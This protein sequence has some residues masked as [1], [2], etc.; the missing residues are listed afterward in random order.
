MIAAGQLLDEI[1][2][3]CVDIPQ[4]WL[5]DRGDSEDDSQDDDEQKITRVRRSQR[6]GRR[7]FSIIK[8][9]R[10]KKQQLFLG[11]ARFIN[12]C[13]FAALPQ[14]RTDI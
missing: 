7:D 8:S 13:T 11:P 3:Q 12:V 10:S 9:N 6:T 2:G 4:G 14:S 1:Q 5:G